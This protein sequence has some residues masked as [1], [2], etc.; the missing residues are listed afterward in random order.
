[1]IELIAHFAL[2]NQHEHLH[3][4]ETEGNDTSL[5]SRQQR[6]HT[7]TDDPGGII[8]QS[9]SDHKDKQK[10]KKQMYYQEIF[11]L[12]EIR[13]DHK[14]TVKTLLLLGQHDS[15]QVGC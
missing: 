13:M 2:L 9:S 3:N 5:K 15:N 7:N 11:H 6:K 10:L 1:M 12:N 4:M 14:E 8:M